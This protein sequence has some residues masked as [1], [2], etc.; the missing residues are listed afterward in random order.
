M[1]VNYSEAQMKSHSPLVIFS[2]NLKKCISYVGPGVLKIALTIRIS[3]VLRVFTAVAA[4]KGHRIQW[5]I[6][7]FNKLYKKSADHVQSLCGK[8]GFTKKMESSA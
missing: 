8:G 5:S 1:V 2:Q 6:Q 7:G 3:H 4:T